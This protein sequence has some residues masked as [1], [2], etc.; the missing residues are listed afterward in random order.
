MQIILSKKKF[1]KA[2]VLTLVTVFILVV[3]VLAQGN[4]D[5]SDTTPISL[6]R[7]ALSYLA[8]IESLPQSPYWPNIKPQ[9]FLENLKMD[10]EA[11]LKMYEGSNTN[12]CSYAALSF[13]PLHDDPLGF[14]KMMIALYTDGKAVCGKAT[15]DPTSAV[16]QVAGTLKFK[17]ILDIHPANQLWFLSLADHFKGYLNFFN[18]HF[19]A[20]DEDKF[21]A[22]CNYAKF[23]RMIKQLFNYKVDA[24]GSDLIGPRIK[25]IYSYLNK[26]LQT[27]T[28]ILFLNNAS[29]HKKKH[30]TRR[31]A[32]PTHFLVLLG[33]EKVDD[34]IKITYWDYG[35]RSLR[36]VTPKFLDKIIFGVSHCTKKIYVPQ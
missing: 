6:Q 8:K 7:D 28:T 32:I 11:P 30:S 27:G 22:A 13:L 33:M 9:A 14:S 29:L 34:I 18:R 23:N 35:G 16:K 15:L 3:D 12:F 17:G 21:W 19:D 24:R 36:E 26:R 20:G 1:T 5:A 2:F 25:D 4:G 31:P 10:V